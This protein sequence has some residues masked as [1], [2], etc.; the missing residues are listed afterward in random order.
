MKGRIPITGLSLFDKQLT[1]C[2]C[3]Y[4]QVLRDLLYL[5]KGP[6]FNSWI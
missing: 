2:V 5:K 6:V 1:A 4:L 3:N